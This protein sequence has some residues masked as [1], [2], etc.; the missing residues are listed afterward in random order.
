[1]FKALMLGLHKRIDRCERERLKQAKLNRE[2]RFQEVR[3]ETRKAAGRLAR[4]KALADMPLPMRKRP[5][6][7]M[8]K[9]GKQK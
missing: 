8:T 9:K 6:T 1:M 5:K 3:V 7:S 4:T 2:T